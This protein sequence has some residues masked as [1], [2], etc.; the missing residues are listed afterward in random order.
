MMIGPY[1]LLAIALF[2]V[3]ETSSL[4]SVGNGL[5]SRKS[6]EVNGSPGMMCYADAYNSLGNNWNRTY[7]NN[8][9]QQLHISLTD[10]ATFARVQFATLGEIKNSYLQ[11]WPK[12]QNHGHHLSKKA[13]ITIKGE[14]IVHND[15]PS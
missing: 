8:E 11:Y 12:K 9:P 15:T 7:T 2:A 10:D 14:V 6:E 4:F 5:S 3:A 13:A 1:F